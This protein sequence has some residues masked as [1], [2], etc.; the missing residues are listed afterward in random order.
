MSEYLFVSDSVAPL[1]RGEAAKSVRGLARGLIELKHRVTILT[2]A[3]SEDAGRI[4]GLARRLRKARVE[5]SEGPQEFGLFEGQFSASDP[6]LL[7]LEAAPANTAEAAV[8]LGGAVASLTQDGLLKPE[9]VVGWDEAS[10]VALARCGAAAKLF[11]LP[12][13]ESSMRFDALQAKQ[14]GLAP[15]DNAALAAFGAAAA[16][17][18]IAPTRSAAKHLEASADLSVRPSDE[19]IVAVPFGADEPPFDPA[20][21]PALPAPFDAANPA[22]RLESRKALLKRLSL[23]ADPRVPLLGTGP[24]LEGTGGAALIGALEGIGRRDVVVVLPAAGDRALVERAAV[25]AIEHPTKIALLQ[26]P[27]E[28]DHRLMLAACDAWWLLDEQDVT[29]REAGRALRYGALPLLSERS[30]AADTLVEWDALSRTGNA[31]FFRDLSSAALEATVARVSS[32]KSD[33]A[34]WNVLQS[35]LLATAPGWKRAA[36]LIDGLRSAAAEEAD[37]Q[38]VALP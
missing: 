14:V 15:G 18:V 31:F 26:E 25:F 1:G 6:Q 19:P 23:T 38:S 30:S 16:Q 32:V 24:R 10:V 34:R 33:A 3:T 7:V 11:V 17:A 28:E 27:T 20:N 29:G 21:D 4:P 35:R 36:M 13:G 2:L 37:L 8:Y 9:V 22:G 5:T 12:Q